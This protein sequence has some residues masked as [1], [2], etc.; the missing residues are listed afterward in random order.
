MGRVKEQFLRHK[1]VA[2]NRPSPY[3]VRKHREAV[4]RLKC[5]YWDFLLLRPRS[6]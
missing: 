2:Y 4:N 3:Y 5:G 1:G 6:K